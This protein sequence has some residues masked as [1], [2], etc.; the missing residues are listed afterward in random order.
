MTEGFDALSSKVPITA[1]AKIVDRWS[2]AKDPD[3]I[4]DYIKED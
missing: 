3:Y 1:E 4:P 2:Q